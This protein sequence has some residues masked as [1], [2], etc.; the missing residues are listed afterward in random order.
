[1]TIVITIIWN[2][3]KLKYGFDNKK[4]EST[5][6]TGYIESLI[7]SI[8]ISTPTKSAFLMNKKIQFHCLFDFHI[9]GYA[10]LF[11]NFSFNIIG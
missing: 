6:T 9:T 1:M 11:F 10:Q 8:R 3:K 7:R 4:V 5:G 2:S